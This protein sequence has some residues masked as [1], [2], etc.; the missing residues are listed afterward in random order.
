MKLSSMARTAARLTFGGVGKSGSPGPR[1]TMSMPR[2]RSLAALAAAF[3]VA[4]T[5]IREMRWE[6]RVG[7]G[8]DAT[9]PSRPGS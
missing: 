3:M 7:T 1:S 4:E 8:M 5:L 6:R 2:A 9:R